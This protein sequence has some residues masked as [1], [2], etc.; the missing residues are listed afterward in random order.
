MSLHFRGDPFP[1]VGWINKLMM[2]EY[3]VSSKKT[4]TLF[5]IFFSPHQVS[6]AIKSTMTL[7]HPNDLTFYFASLLLVWRYLFVTFTTLVPHLPHPTL[8]QI[9]SLQIIR[10]HLGR[11]TLKISSKLGNPTTCLLSRNNVSIANTTRHF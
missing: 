7:V 8:E 1:V 6:S 4:C 10:R 3:V 11:Q 5:S 9:F 2:N